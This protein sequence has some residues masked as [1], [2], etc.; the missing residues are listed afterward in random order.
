M[1][2]NFCYTDIAALQESASLKE[3][4]GMNSR[5][6]ELVASL[7]FISLFYSSLLLLV[8]VLD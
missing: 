6:L 4:S 7:F 5:N 1:R 3:Q 8:L 2:N